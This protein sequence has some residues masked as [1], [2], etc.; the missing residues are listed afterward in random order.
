MLSDDSNRST[1]KGDVGYA[2][3]GRYDQEPTYAKHIPT[4]IAWAFEV[5]IV[6][7]VSKMVVLST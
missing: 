1:K 2:F 5:L 6:T 3:G 7:Y 4:P